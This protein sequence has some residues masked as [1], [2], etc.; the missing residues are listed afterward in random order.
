MEF[1]EFKGRF[2][3]V[4]EA[5]QPV[6][7][8]SEDVSR[9]ALLDGLSGLQ[10]APDR[11]AFLEQLMTLEARNRENSQQR[12][13]G[14]VSHATALFDRYAEGRD[15]AIQE[16]L[17]QVRMLILGKAEVHPYADALACGLVDCVA[18]G[19]EEEFR[20][21]RHAALRDA[22]TV[23]MEEIRKASES[24]QTM[25]P[26]TEQHFEATRAG[27]DAEDWPFLSAMLCVTVAISSLASIQS[28]AELGLQDETQG[29]AF[30]KAMAEVPVHLLDGIIRDGIQEM[31]VAFGL[32]EEAPTP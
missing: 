10:D 5:M 13:A 30:E 22:M 2:L 27:A 24:F 32:E 21:A 15:E 20:A 26:H 3:P 4:M 14:M 17:G 19:S 23:G 25:L 8:I 9:R 31:V 6:N 7:K 12:L 1:P 28:K 16:A 29:V 11:R 18:A